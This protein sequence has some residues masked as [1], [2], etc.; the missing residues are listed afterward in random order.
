MESSLTHTPHIKASD[1][2]G[3]WEPK[4]TLTLEA[5]RRHSV[6]IRILRLVLISLAIAL[7]ASL[8][9]QFATQKTSFIVDDN[10]GESVK[11]VNPRYSGRTNDGLPYR[12]KSSSAIRLTPN[13]QE[14]VLEGPVL[15]FVRSVNATP[16]ILTA[17]TGQYNDVDQVLDLKTAVD[18]RTDDGYH[19]TSTHARVFAGAKRIE[20]DAAILCDG[21]FGR[22][23][24]QSYE[25]LNN[26]SEFVFRGGTDAYLTPNK[27]ALEP[28]DA[29]LTSAPVKKEPPAQKSNLPE[30]GFAGNQPIS[31]KAETATYKSGLTVL[32]GT[33]DVTQGAARI[34]SDEMYIYREV[35]KDDAGGSLRLGALSEIDARGNFRYTAPDNT[36]TGNRGVYNQITGVMTVTGNVRVTQP[37]GNII[38]SER[39]TY[40]VRDKTIRFGNECVGKKCGNRTSLRF[41]PEN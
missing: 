10:P 2:L 22:V 24:G 33:V 5:A 6:R 9:W 19:C 23:T 20:G 34:E 36:V 16:S 35:S 8:A 1:T 31:V 7:V 15:S 28:E 14:V 3:L 17:K 11:M 26:Y 4:R 12:L 38:K 13:T 27:D 40:N 39:L 37:S 29:S 21:S 25:I 18:L 30:F 41:A 32:N